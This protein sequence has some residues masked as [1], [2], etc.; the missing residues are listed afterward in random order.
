MVHVGRNMQGFS[1]TMKSVASMWIRQWNFGIIGKFA[2]DIVALYLVSDDAPKVQI[3]DVNFISIFVAN[4][5][6]LQI[7]SCGHFTNFT[8]LK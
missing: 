8:P 2:S 3:F 1:V 7:N 5:Q 6:Y 4:N